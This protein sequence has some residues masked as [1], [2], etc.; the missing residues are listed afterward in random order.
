MADDSSSSVQDPLQL[1]GPRSWCIGQKCVTVIYTA[2]DEHVEVHLH[3]PVNV[4]AC[5]N[6]EILGAD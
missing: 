2:V 3:G 4:T 6:E 1:V 5:A